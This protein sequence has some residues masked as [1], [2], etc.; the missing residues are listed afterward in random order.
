MF[1]FPFQNYEYKTAKLLHHLTAKQDTISVL[2]ILLKI[3]KNIMVGLVVF[4][5]QINLLRLKQ[6]LNQP[7]LLKTCDI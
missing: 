1:P 4:K 5:T 6:L 3:K 7:V 2:L